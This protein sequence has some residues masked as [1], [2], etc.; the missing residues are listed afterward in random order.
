MHEPVGPLKSSG[1]DFLD[2]LVP[3][4]LSVDY[5]GRVV[6][7]DTFSKTVAPGCRLGWI[8]AQPAL[9][10]RLLRITETSTQQPSGFVQSVIAELI[11]GPHSKHGKG[12]GSNDKGWQTDGWVRW[13]EGLRGNYERRMNTMCSILEEGKEIVK[14]GRRK[15]LSSPAATGRQDPDETAEWSVVEK[16][17]IY[18]FAWPLG[19]MFLWL[20]VRF[21]THPLFRKLPHDALMRGLFIHL[22]TPRYRVLASPGTIFAATDDIKQDRAWRYFRLCFAAV[23]EDLL[24]GMTRKLV[25]GIHTFWGKKKVDDVETLAAMELELEAAPPGSGVLANMAGLGC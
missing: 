11:M 7:L 20:H 2:S 3:S 14:A 9:C 24:D 21:E 5:E 4:Y 13:L 12:G 17:Q 15:S 19:G 22:T 6:R 18:D 25:K 16:T 1:Y 8:T 10:E 23:D